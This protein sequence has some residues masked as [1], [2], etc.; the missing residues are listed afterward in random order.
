MKLSYSALALAR[1]AAGESK[2]ILKFPKCAALA[3]LLGPTTGAAQDVD[4][5]MAG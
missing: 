3:L 4:A 5:A 2:I 1:L